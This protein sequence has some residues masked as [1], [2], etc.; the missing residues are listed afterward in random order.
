VELKLT[1]QE[2]ALVWL[3]P[4]LRFSPLFTRTVSARLAEGRL[5]GM[6][7]HSWVTRCLHSHSVSFRYVGREGDVPLC[8]K[9]LKYVYTSDKPA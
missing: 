3:D 9:E 4:L 2:G 1:W 6:G 7:R 8:K 5:L